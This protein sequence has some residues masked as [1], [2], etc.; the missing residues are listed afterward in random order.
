MKFSKQDIDLFKKARNALPMSR[1]LEVM[2]EMQRTCNALHTYL[3]SI[4]PENWAICFAEAKGIMLHGM[5]TDNLV[6][7]VFAFIKPERLLSVYFCVQEVT[8]KAL[9]L[10][11]EERCASFRHHHKL[12]PPARVKFEESLRLYQSKTYNMTWTDPSRSNYS[13]CAQRS[14]RSYCNN[15]SC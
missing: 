7:Q 11:S 4:G 2:A 3:V 14:V 10:F 12:T 9:R 5:M 8:L 1:H 6:E 15:S 13:Y